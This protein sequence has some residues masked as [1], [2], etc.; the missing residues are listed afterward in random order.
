MGAVAIAIY[1]DKNMFIAS[2][3]LYNRVV[4]LEKKLSDMISLDND[5]QRDVSKS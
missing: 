2:G 5:T 1:K 4:R 3:K